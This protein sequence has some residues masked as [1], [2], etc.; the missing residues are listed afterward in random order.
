MTHRCKNTSKNTIRGI[1]TARVIQMAVH[2]SERW[3][4]VREYSKRF[5]I[6][7]KTV[8][9]DLKVLELAGVPIMEEP[10]IDRVGG[11]GRINM[12]YRVDAHWMRKFL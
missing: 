10:Q 9:R 11:R 5:D 8:Y 3:Y 6:T 2:L 1:Q 7:H 4:T 12:Q